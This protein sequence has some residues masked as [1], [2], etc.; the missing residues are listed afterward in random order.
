MSVWSRLLQ[1]S[2]RWLPPRHGFVFDEELQGSLQE[3]AEREARPPN[4]VAAD[5]LSFALEER[6]AGEA[7]LRCWHDLTAREQ[8]VVAL[9]C[10]DYSTR[11]IAARLVISPETVKSHLRKALRKFGLR[12]KTQL[13]QAL[14]GWD[15]R[16][17]GG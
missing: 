9:L 4:A 7:Y 6:L 3:L 16:E 8:Q 13:R 11:Q 14:A 2:G 10:Q 12:N 15:F 5:L 1:I 17:W